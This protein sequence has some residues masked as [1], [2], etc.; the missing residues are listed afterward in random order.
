MAFFLNQASHLRF[1]LCLL[2]AGSGLAMPLLL[3]A[4][5]PPALESWQRYGQPLQSAWF[6]RETAAAQSLNAAAPLPDGRMLFAGDEFLL[7]DGW[8]WQVQR[9]P[10]LRQVS[11]LAADSRGRTWLAAENELGFL[12]LD[13]SGRLRYESCFP[14]FLQSGFSKGYVW[15]I[16]PAGD[17]LLF[18]GADKVWNWQNGLWREFSFN[19]RYRLLPFRAGSRIFLQAATS[20]YEWDG[21]Q[22]SLFADSPLLDGRG[23]FHA[24]NEADG[25]L[26]ML[27]NRGYVRLSGGHLQPGPDWIWPASGHIDFTRA[28]PLP[29]GLTALGT[30]G[31][32]ILLF[33]G[34]GRWV[35]TFQPHRNRPWKDYSDLAVDRQGGLWMVNAEG[36]A[37]LDTRFP[38]R[39]SHRDWGFPLET[40]HDAAPL[41]SSLFVATSAGLTALPRPPR[42]LP[43]PAPQPFP[44]DRPEAVYALEPSAPSSL[45]LATTHRLGLWRE[46]T[47]LL[48]AIPDLTQTDVLPSR[49]RPG[50]VWSATLHDVRLLNLTGPEALELA[51][52]NGLSGMPHHLVEDGSGSLWV[53]TLAG[54]LYRF[55]GTAHNLTTAP[56]ES[57][58]FPGG[59]E[60]FPGDFALGLSQG[61]AL[62]ITP[63]GLFRDDG[64]GQI[65]PFV[66]SPVCADPD[67][68]WVIPTQIHPGSL[69]W[70]AQRHRLTGGSR[71]LRL[72]DAPGGPTRVRVLPVPRLAELGLL[73][74]IVELPGHSTP[75]VAVLGSEAID[76]IQYDKLAPETTPLPPLLRPGEGLSPLR[77][78]EKGHPVRFLLGSPQFDQG[79]PFFFQTRLPSIDPD[80][81]A[82]TRQKVWSFSGLRAGRYAFE[83]RL[84]GPTGLVSPPARLEF[85]VLPPWYRTPWALGLWSGLLVALTGAAF[86]GRLLA[87]RRHARVLE[88]KV[89]LRTAELEKASR[90][91]TDFIAS[92]SHEIRN[93]LNGIIGPLRQWRP[94]QPLR[95]ED[96]S[97]L[98]QRAYY[99]HRLVGNI[100]DFA[101]LE[102]GRLTVRREIFNPVLL[103]ETVLAL[104]ED[105]AREHRISLAVD[106]RGPAATWIE[107]DRAL[108]EQV[109]VNLVS[110]SIRFTAGGAIG[111]GIKI[112]AEPGAGTGFL[113]LWVKD[114]GAGIAPEDQERIF[115]PF[116]QGSSRSP[117][118]QGEKG[119]GLGLSIV[120]DILTALG[121]QKRFHSELGRGTQ[122]LLT[123]PVNLHPAALEAGAPEDAR[124]TGRF[125]VADDIGYNRDL[126]A[127]LL[128]SWGAEIVTAAD[129][130][131]V[132]RLL[133]DQ[134][135]DALFLDW[136]LPAYTGPEIASFVRK[137]L[138]PR[139]TA[140][141]LVAQTAYVTESHRQACAAA[142]M[143]IFLEKPVSPALLLAA[144][145]THR[146][147]WVT[148][149][150]P[151]PGLPAPSLPSPDMLAFLA[152]AR[153]HSLAVEIQSFSTEIR[154]F[155]SHLE[156]LEPSLHARLIREELHKI[157]GH[158]GI[159]QDSA[160]L[161]FF[162]QW[163]AE[164]DDG[165]IHTAFSQR[166]QQAREAFDQVQRRLAGWAELDAD[167]FRSS[168]P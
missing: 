160:A 91:K 94:G 81:S 150:S 12:S 38:L 86:Y 114:N 153:G 5:P 148:A 28:Q 74:A 165:R 100:L 19:A 18:F 22:F 140:A 70:L 158:L 44:A 13:S 110:N 111:V 37:R 75:L 137:G 54:H 34:S 142:G 2:A 11:A 161:A 85:T 144:L 63:G 133:S 157:C 48:T 112:D 68:E 131:E 102:R 138:F 159:I 57:V 117:V 122:F 71:L 42:G 149:A 23:V 59:G 49:A 33:D 9:L 90:I 72:E 30:L 128:S 15:S 36:L 139:N 88:E 119:T 95:E 53:K 51:R 164:I 62:V 155:F 127:G 69:L 16:E 39:R 78:P 25:S 73:R 141:L 3:P 6:W 126:L 129:G 135:F 166:L 113:R 50:F 92:V 116:M 145:R 80:W 60:K 55:P 168:P 136:E 96:L 104:F 29:D 67:W 47:G 97:G 154:Q 35:E 151:P 61:R 56:R 121:G 64:S 162:R 156:S 87:L 58:V 14:A 167:F 147:D 7:Y 108:L 66:P 77:F 20:L 45:L 132:L 146:P 76:W 109:L 43:A 82:P 84:L 79:R 99:L 89:R 130:N 105:A 46:D 106:F 101:K 4:S 123:F 83:A 120:R 124:L 24:W 152:T 27:T 98:R 1:P 143:E 17:A 21:R 41:G 118:G 10:G 40:I 65:F 8:D 32:G 125:L 31:H 107:S 163:I 134:T 115:E 103:K 26:L 52:F 93:P